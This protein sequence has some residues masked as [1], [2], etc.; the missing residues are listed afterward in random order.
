MRTFRKGLLTNPISFLG[1]KVLFE[2]IGGGNG[3][4]KLDEQQDSALIAE[5]D[6]LAEARRMGVTRISGEIYEALKKNKPET[7]SRNR[8]P[9]LERLRILD[10]EKLLPPKTQKSSPA[11]TES[12]IATPAAIKVPGAAT[13]P[14]AYYTRHPIQL[15]QSPSQP[16]KVAPAKPQTQPEASKEASKEPGAIKPVK[17]FKPR[18]AKAAQVEAKQAK[19]QTEQ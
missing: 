14:A 11:G 6:R 19:P 2:P 18:T 17:V 7:P 16:I 8:R 15:S 9:R 1:K 5:L 12:A 13:V 10:R 3:V 4:I